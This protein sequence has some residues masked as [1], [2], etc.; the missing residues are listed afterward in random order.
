MGEILYHAVSQRKVTSL[1]ETE[2]PLNIFGSLLFFVL[3]GFSFIPLTIETA[4]IHTNGDLFDQHPDFFIQ[5][6]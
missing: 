6:Y 4:F 5:I 1:Q 3:S 2:L